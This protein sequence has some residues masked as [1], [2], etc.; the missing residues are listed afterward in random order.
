MNRQFFTQEDIV[1]YHWVKFN[2]PSSEVLYALSGII[3]VNMKGN[4]QNWLGNDIKCKMNI[5]DLPA[6]QGIFIRYHAPFASLNSI[7]NQNQAINGGHA[8]DTCQLVDIH[9][10]G[11][12]GT[13]ELTLALKLAVRDTDAY[14][15]R[16]GFNIIFTGFLRALPPVDPC[17]D[18][19]DA[20]AR[21]QRMCNGG[22]QGIIDSLQELLAT[23]TTQQKEGI[24]DAIRE[25]NEKIDRCPVD[26]ANAEKA[27]ASCRI[28]DT[29]IDPDN[30][31]TSANRD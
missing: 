17:K 5:P 19:A 18:E 24:M 16:V 1:S 11:N 31:I 27:L 22:Y 30:V 10:N 21:L 2:G 23:A 3:L 25:L 15:Y 4:S 13:K 14:L 6:G 8:V 12:Y 28:R 7:Y 9:P 26:I 29:H 20:L